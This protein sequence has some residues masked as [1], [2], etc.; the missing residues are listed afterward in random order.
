[1]CDGAVGS[2]RGP[3]ARMT[4]LTLALTLGTAWPTCWPTPDLFSKF[5]HLHRVSI[6]DLERRNES[7]CET[8][9][10][11]S[12]S[13]HRGGRRADDIGSLR[14]RRAHLPDRDALSS[15]RASPVVRWETLDLR[16]GCLCVQP[17]RGVPGK[18][19]I[20]W[21]FLDQDR[22]QRWRSRG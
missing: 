21:P 3:V 1:M 4:K 2:I 12:R 7:E 10:P 11:G 19:G 17:G 20:G 9:G 5:P 13:G 22:S 16:P 14:L 8:H 6:H 18:S 15:Q